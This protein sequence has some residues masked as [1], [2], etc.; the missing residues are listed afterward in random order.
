MTNTKHMRA[1]RIRR[2]KR[3][4]FS[5]T[6]TAMRPRISVFRSNRYLS[7]QL[8]DDES[9]HTLIGMSTKSLRAAGKRSTKT[10]CAARLGAL[11][12]EAAQKRNI[13]KAVLHRGSYRY[14]GQVR[15]FTEAARKSGLR[16]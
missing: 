15:A 7:A 11:V 9:G 16:I 10:E 13:T 14:H 12:A 5:V 2:K 8:I 3:S 4:R 6:G 1:R